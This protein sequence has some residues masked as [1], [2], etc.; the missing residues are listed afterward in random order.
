MRDPIGPDEQ[1]EVIRGVGLELLAVARE[2]WQELE[3]SFR[4]TV[5]VDTAT[6]WCTGADGSRSRL[7][8]PGGAM[9]AL[10]KLRERMYVED[11]GSWFTARMRIIPPGRFT[12]D[13]DYDGE[14]EFV[15][16]LT[17]DTFVADLQHFPRAPEHIPSWLAEKLAEAEADAPEAAPRRLRLG[18]VLRSALGRKDGGAGR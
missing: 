3:L 10:G 9:D 13:Y 4:S 14:P 16:P 1:A 8:P 7:M 18:S 15:P 5:V 12:V 6:L 2:G 11:K 17:P